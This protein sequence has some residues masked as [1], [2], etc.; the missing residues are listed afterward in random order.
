MRAQSRAQW[1]RLRACARARSRWAVALAGSL[2]AVA[3]AL[4]AGAN[5]TSA[6]DT[7]APAAEKPARPAP[8]ARPTESDPNPGD[9]KRAPVYQAPPSR[10]AP[11]RRV[12]GATRRAG[13]R[14][15]IVAL[16]PDH[17]GRTRLPAPT[18]FWYSSAESD[19][20]LEFSLMAR[21]GDADPAPVLSLTVA[22]RVARGI[23]SLSLAEY[24]V[25]L[26]PGVV[27]R[28]YVA[29]VLDADRRAHDVVAGAAL[30][31]VA[32]MPA[33]LVPGIGAAGI[34]A[35]EGFWYDALGA[36]QL[37]L[38]PAESPAGDPEALAAARHALLSQVGI[39]PSDR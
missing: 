21:R 22:P 23:G 13:P 17:V 35:R 24:G 3:L 16:G 5:A 8:G 4:P 7:R 36:I 39:S 38:D 15:E 31:R 10:G 9:A 26:E 19:A 29:A 30:E 33:R 34:Y 27:Y 28:W 18:L 6:Q 1:N 25:E 12:G 20:P 2:V 32:R 14:P 11:E 37:G